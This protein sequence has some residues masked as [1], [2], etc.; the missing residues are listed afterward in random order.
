[1]RAA[2]RAFL[3][4]ARADASRVESLV[5]L[6]RVSTWRV[7]HEADAAER[8]RIVAVALEAAQW[9]EKRAPASAACAYALAQ[10]L[11]QQARERPSTSHDGL[12]QMVRALERAAA[13][14]P[15]LDD[16]GPWRVLALVKLRAPGWPLGPGDA[17]AGLAAAEQAT[18]L[19]P[20]HPAN[21]LALAEALA[22]NGRVTEALAAYDRALTLARAR[23]ASGDP[24][25][26]A[27]VEEAERGLGLARRGAAGRP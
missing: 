16:A 17:A 21:Q 19:A 11:G 20:D 4:A 27:W 7:E 9:C 8:E 15:G 1:V 10:A 5:G 23:A 22:R 3:A 26:S 12:Q 24:D 25:A 6:A 2:E 18:G 14:E 13:A